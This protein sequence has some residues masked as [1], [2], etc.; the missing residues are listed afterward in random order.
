MNEAGLRVWD[1]KG[2]DIYCQGTTDSELPVSVSVSFSLDGVP[3]SAEEL[4]GKSGRVKIRFDY[5]N[6][7]SE[8]VEIDG[9]KEDI[10]VPFAMLTGVLLDGNVFQ[11]LKFQTESLLTTATG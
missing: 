3:V 2:N 4:A 8:T 5:I 7:C 10:H 11:T 6:K 1:A 9:K